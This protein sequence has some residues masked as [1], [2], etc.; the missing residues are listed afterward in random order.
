MKRMPLLE[1]NKV[2]NSCVEKL[3]FDTTC[4]YGEWNRDKILRKIE[5]LL[6]TRRKKM[7]SDVEE[8][9]T[10]ASAMPPMP[11]KVKPSKAKKPKKTKPK[12]AKVKAKAKKPKKAKAKIVKRKTRQK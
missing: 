2:A 6:R 5:R 9:V 12:K 1:R 7:G 10:V 8:V 3:L 4:R 11:P